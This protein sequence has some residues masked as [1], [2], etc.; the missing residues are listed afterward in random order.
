MDQKPDAIPKWVQWT[1]SQM[2]YQNGYS[3]PKWVQWTTNQMQY[4][5]GYSGPKTRCNTKMGSIPWCS[6]GFFSQSAVSVNSLTVFIQSP[7][8]SAGIHICVHIIIKHWQLYHCADSQRYCIHCSIG[9]GKHCS[10]ICF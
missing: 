3:G 8:A 4:L 2:Q 1:K 6:R 5:N 10:C 9:N 7:C